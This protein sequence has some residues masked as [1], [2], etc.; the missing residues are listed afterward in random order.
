MTRETPLGL[1]EGAGLQ[2]VVLDFEAESLGFMLKR[3]TGSLPGSRQFT[4]FC[5]E[6][7]E[8]LG[9]DDSAPPPLYYFTIGALF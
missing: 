6:P 9:G 2:E 1:R 4:V 3:G 5:D 8:L 7:P